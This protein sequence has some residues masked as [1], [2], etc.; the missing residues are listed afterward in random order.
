M[1]ILWHPLPDTGGSRV[2]FTGSLVNQTSARDRR[3][4]EAD[5]L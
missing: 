2:G 5:S 4:T 3:E 1:L